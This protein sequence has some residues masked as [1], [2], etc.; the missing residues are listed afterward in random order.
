MSNHFNVNRW[1]EI[2]VGGDRRGPRSTRAEIDGLQ[3]E[4]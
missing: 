1:A 3:P 4:P 2:D